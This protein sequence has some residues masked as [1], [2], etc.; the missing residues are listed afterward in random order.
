M[1]RKVDG[2]IFDVDGTLWDARKQV[3]EAWNEVIQKELGRDMGLSFD[4]F[5]G[6]F[7]LPSDVIFE[8]LFPELV[9]K[10]Q[11]RIGLKCFEYEN[12]YL[13]KN[14]G[15]VY[16]GMPETLEKL[17]SQYELFVVSNCG[18]GYIEACLTSTGLE[19][20]FK[21]TLSYGDTLLYKGNNI[22]TIMEKN[23][24]ENAIYVGDVQGDADASQEA[25]IPIIYAAYGFGTILK[26]E[27]VIER[28]S[29]LIKL[30]FKT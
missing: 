27:A 30:F 9:K 23:H 6:L 5:T 4:E 21:D 25:G 7:G 20:Y 22:K 3:A 28:P 26:P 19:K 8:K 1:D 14:P 15:K 10:E 29:D 24:L 17:K 13:R 18:K 16:E 12:L 11:E 2:I